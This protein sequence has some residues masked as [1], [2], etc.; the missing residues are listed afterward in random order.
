MARIFGSLRLGTSLAIVGLVILGIGAPVGGSPSSNAGAGPGT[1]LP[2]G[3]EGCVLQGIGAPATKDDVANLDKWQV[4]EGGSTN[5]TA[6]YNPFN[7]RQVTDSKGNALPV[8]ASSDAFPAFATWA[9][10]CSATVATLLQ[11]SMAPIVTALRAG[12]VAPPGLFLL[13]VDRSP[14]CAPS[15]DGIPCYAGEVLA[16]ELLQALLN[17]GSGQLRDALTSYSNTGADLHS[18]EQ[19]AFVTEVDQAVLAA[20]N[21]QLAA[22]EN[23]VS[24]AQGKL[25]VAALG[26]RELV[27]HDYMNDGKVRADQN[28]QMFGPPDEQGVVAQY[29]GNVASS[30]LIERYDRAKAAVD[31][32][33]ARQQVA[34]AFVAQA[35]SVLDAAQAVQSQALLGLDADVKTI[36]ESRA[37]TAPPVAMPAASSVAGPASAGELWVTL[38]N[39][40]VGPSPPVTPT[41]GALHS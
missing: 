17:G 16:G 20:K 15:A 26:L 38:Q 36:E 40:L 32:S 29:L 11:L 8:V 30:L 33:M 13:A 18:Y 12:N 31:A 25:S 23:E 34:A 24:A 1:P 39:C 5:N 10:G 4:A 9:D 7:T 21:G 28:V 27:L 41:T 35:T 14:W 22:I 6:A 19:A 2:L 37:C 3:W